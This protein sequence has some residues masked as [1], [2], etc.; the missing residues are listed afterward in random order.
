MYIYNLCN[1]DLLDPC[2]QKE[3]SIS[4]QPLNPWH[5]RPKPN[6]LI[7]D[8]RSFHRCLFLHLMQ[9]TEIWIS[10]SLPCQNSIIWIIPTPPLMSRKFRTHGYPCKQ[11]NIWRHRPKLSMNLLVT[12][13]QSCFYPFQLKS[14]CIPHMTCDSF[15]S[16]SISCV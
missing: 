15:I 11:K 7:A 8:Y 16:S 6:E 12:C 14:S 9:F 10:Q 4:S 3:C 13:P 2:V 5:P 1:I